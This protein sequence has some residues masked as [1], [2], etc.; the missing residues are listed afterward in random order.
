MGTRFEVAIVTD[1]AADVRR[2]WA[3]AR[4]VDVRA[5]GESAL[6]E[7]E[8]WHQR[9]T[10]FE[11]DSWLS[12]VNRTAAH[13][14][15][16]LDDE[17]FPLFAD[18]IDVWRDS[19]GAF[20]IA[21]GDGDAIAL[22]REARTLRFLHDHVS[23]DLGAIGK[24]HALDCAAARLR[25]HGV[26]R[27]FLQGGTSSGL[28]I[29]TPPDANAWRVG[30]A[31]ESGAATVEDVLELVDES[32]S[33]SDE[34]SQPDVPFGRHIADPRL[35]VTAPPSHTPRRVV[36]TGPSARLADA[37]STALAVLGEV[38]STFPAGYR[39]RFLRK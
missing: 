39:A 8:E 12:H 21:R 26:T 17:V 29:G 32:F 10:R 36:V 31:S 4:A 16:R 24:G 2:T 5:V 15:V 7:I 6:R 30:L 23:L 20:D 11:S 1:A 37:W 9:L 25:S 19:S 28:A 13:E 27:A 22:D 35:K 18:A 34:A 38:P 33:L 14:P 3:S